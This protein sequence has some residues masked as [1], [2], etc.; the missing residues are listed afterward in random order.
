MAKEFVK[1]L[2][3]EK[4][5]PLSKEVADSIK[6]THAKKLKQISEGAAIKK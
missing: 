5:C 2:T 3:K 4:A 6:K 1:D